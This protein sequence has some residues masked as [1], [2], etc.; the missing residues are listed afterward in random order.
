[1]SGLVHHF[2]LSWKYMG[3]AEPVVLSWLVTTSIT[4]S[5]IG[6]TCDACQCFYC[7]GLQEVFERTQV[8][9]GKHSENLPFPDKHSIV[10][11]EKVPKTGVLTKTKKRKGH[12]FSSGEPSFS[13]KRCVVSRHLQLDL[14]SYAMLDAVQK[15]LVQHT[16]RSYMLCL[17]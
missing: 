9:S 10:V 12:Q 13:M 14:M 3:Q 15:H 2:P 7:C 17:K 6:S 5:I 1:V 4:F 16:M 11:S 8:S